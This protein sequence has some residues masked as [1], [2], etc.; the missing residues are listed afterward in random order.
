MRGI[1]ALTVALMHV[2][3][4]FVELP[5]RSVLDKAGL[6]A[7]QA[8]SNGYGAV[9]AFFV[10]SG[11]V[12]A[13][14]LDRNFDIVRFVIARVFR[15][16]PAA[17]ATVATFAAVHYCFGFSVYPKASF[18][19]LNVL[20]NMLML[21]VDIDLVMWSMKAEVAATPLIILCA[22]LFRRYG[23]GTVIAVA[24]ALFALAFVGQFAKSIG[25]DTNLA[26]IFAF[27]VGILVHFKGRDVAAKLTPAAVALCAVASVAVF[28]ACAFFKPS[29][30]WTLLV[31]CLSAATLVML[32]A[33]RAEATTFAPL[34]LAVVRLYGRISYSF[35]LLHPLA[36]WGA[37]RLM[38]Y[39]IAQ[40]D[41]VPVTVIVI[42]AFVLSVV[43]ITPLA[44]LSWRFVELPA[45]NRLRS[46]PASRG[47]LPLG[48]LPGD[49]HVN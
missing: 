25:D 28:C 29:G 30:T 17:I 10:I 49:Q 23:M 7:V 6:F 9:V 38:V 14:S 33:W 2:S 12:L 27:P 37:N 24:V 36:L 42:A 18:A 19:P 40:F 26:P 13:R 32:I 43:F 8:L 41:S 39:S 21:R 20:A 34:D 4:S 15:L 47:V 3:S 22:W 16:Y 11:F 45:M 31:Q 48:A 35:Y 44:W 1:A 5:G 46:V